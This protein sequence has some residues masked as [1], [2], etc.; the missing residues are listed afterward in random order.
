MQDITEEN[1]FNIIETEDTRYVGIVDFVTTKHVIMY[2][3]S[4][5][6]D[7][8]CR[9]LAISHKLFYSNMR[10]SIFKSLFANHLSFD[11]PVLINRK[12]IKYT[13]VPLMRTTIKR[14]V[15]KVKYSK[16]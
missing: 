16:S 3:F 2:D 15:S 6:N 5:N 7:T 8:K 4:N 11:T 12:L 10:F 9:M 14:E 13:S 1:V